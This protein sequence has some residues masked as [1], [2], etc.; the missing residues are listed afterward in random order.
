M[1]EQNGRPR[2]STKWQHSARER[3]M[4]RLSIQGLHKNYGE[5]EVLRGIDLTVDP[6][7]VVCVLGPSGSGKSTMLRCVNLLERYQ[8]GRIVVD[9]EDVGYK[10]V[11]SGLAELS[12]RKIAEHRAHIGMVF[13]H[14]HLFPHMTVLQNITAAPTHVL[15]VDKTE[16]ERQ[17]REL[18]EKVGLDSKADAYPK[19]LSGGQQQRVAIARAMAM[20]PKLML[21]DEPTSA[22]D[23]ELVGEVLDVMRNL[24]RSGMTMLVVTHEIRFARDV[25]DRVIFIDGGVIVE[26]G[27]PESVIDHP[28]SARAQDFFARV[29]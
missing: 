11:P 26:E 29:R 6:G 21:F 5:N 28:K 1:S 10:K 14:F 18:L 19:Q 17:G 20:K 2:G 27:S 13:Q 15:G 23:P 12:E 16:A 25:C 4:S 22:L 8:S 9:G 7:E 24:A 3:G